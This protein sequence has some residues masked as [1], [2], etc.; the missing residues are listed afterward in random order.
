MKIKKALLASAVIAGLSSVSTSQATTLMRASL[1]ELVQ[2][3]HTI[4]AGEVVDMYSYW[5]ADSSF[6]FTDVTITVE[7][8]MK[9]VSYTHL[10]AHE[11]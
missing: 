6:I 1:D 3:N 11:T 9:A 10:R 5:N 7:D 4:I 8:N 2:H